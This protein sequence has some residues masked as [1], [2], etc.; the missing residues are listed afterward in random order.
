MAGQD[1][2]IEPLRRGIGCR[3]LHASV[4]A[5]DAAH[6]RP[7]RHAPAQTRADGVHVALG[8]ALDRVPLRRVAHAQEPVVVEEAHEEAGGHLAHARRRRR[9]DGGAH[10]REEVIGQPAPVAAAL[11]EL[12]DRDAVALRIVEHGAR[13]AEETPEIQ[14]Q[15]GERRPHEIAPL[16]EQ[17]AQPVPGEFE[18]TALAAHRERHG[19]GTQPDSELL[20]ESE[21]NGIVTF[22]ANNEP[23]VERVTAGE[24]CVC[25]SP[26]P[27]LGLE[28]DDIAL[29]VEAMC[30]GEPG[31]AR[32]DDCDFHLRRDSAAAS[33]IAPHRVIIP[34]HSGD[35]P[36]RTRRRR[37][38][39]AAGTND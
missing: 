33:T 27:L 7:Q 8:A 28:Q 14:Q 11:E 37:R 29:R 38:L 26:C 12:A 10:R 31:D 35:Q 16:C 36:S 18:V 20:H 32:A 2:A 21:E 19:R 3:D 15:A 13:I 5:A 9:P 22:V 30:G 23:R 4:V 34:L 39:D 17:S 25:V 1:H 24:Y 6:R